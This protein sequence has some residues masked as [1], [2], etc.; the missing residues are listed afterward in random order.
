MLSPI[1]ALCRRGKFIRKSLAFIILIISN[2]TD[3][4]ITSEQRFNIY[5]FKFNIYTYMEEL[6][7]D[8]IIQI[9]TE[10]K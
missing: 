2:I 6:H 1:Q 7:F 3:I 4:F 8:M 10:H 5:I 9:Y